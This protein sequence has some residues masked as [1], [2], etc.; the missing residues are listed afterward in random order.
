M[1]LW[2]SKKSSKKSTLGKRTRR[3]V[4]ATAAK[5]KR[6]SAAKKTWKANFKKGMWLLRI[7]FLLSLSLGAVWAMTSG[8]ALRWWQQGLTYSVQTSA[9]WGLTLQDVTLEGVGRTD[10]THVRN[11]LKP[12]VGQ[13]ILDLNLE[14]IQKDLL[15]RP[16]VA[17]AQ[18]R[19]VLPQGLVI[20]LE[21]RRPK[22]LWSAQEKLSLLDE[23][24]QVVLIQDL[25]PFAG[26]PVLVGSGANEKGIEFLTLVEKYPD[27]SKDMKS[28]TWISGRRWDL[29]LGS[30]DLKVQLAEES[31]EKSL[32]HLQDLLED[33]RIQWERIDV[34]DLRLEGRAF[35]LLKKG[36]KT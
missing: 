13:P 5:T 34:L 19:R 29:H 9:R 27:I 24:G 36:A 20:T 18:V 6:R 15:K 35:F 25:K 8:T 28:S 1:A 33:D 10:A 2:G 21:E 7:G 26:F 30:K 32:E 17:G 4:T 31:V 3:S 11:A 23:E 12:L 14:D 22:A 16:W